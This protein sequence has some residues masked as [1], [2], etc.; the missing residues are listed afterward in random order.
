GSSA[1][2]GGAGGRYQGVGGQAGFGGGAGGGSN[3]DGQAGGGP[4]F[5]GGGGGQVGSSPATTYGGAAGANG[6]AGGGGAAL[7]GAIFVREGGNLVIEGT[8]TTGSSI[9]AGAGGTGSGFAP[10]GSAGQATGTDIFLMTGTG[11]TVQGTTNTSFT[12]SI[13]SQAGDTGISKSGS[14]ILTLSNDNNSYTGGTSVTGGTM[15]ITNQKNIGTGNLSVSNGGAV[16]ASASMDVKMAVTV[17]GAGSRFTSGVGPAALSIGSTGSG[18]LTVTNGGNATSLGSIVFGDFNGVTG[19]GSVNGTGSSLTATTSVVLGS[20]GTG[21]LSVGSGGTVTTG[22]LVFS[23]NGGPG[24]L[25]LNSGGTLQVGGTNGI[26][27]SGTG[28]FNLAGGI[29]KVTN[30]S[31]TSSMNMI[32]SNS[33]LID[34]SGVEGVLSGVLSGSG[35]LSKTGAGT[36][37]LTGDNTYSGT[38]TLY[39]G[40]LIID[41][42]QSGIGQVS[43]LTGSTLGGDGTLG[44]SLHLEADANLSFDPLETLTIN[45]AAVTFDGFGIR[46]VIGLNAS[47]DIGT[48]TLLNG[49]AAFDFSNVSNFGVNNAYALGGGKFAY[50]QEG[51]FEVVVVPEPS[52]M[53][54]LVL[55]ASLVFYRQKRRSA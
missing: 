30:S 11:L 16:V 15:A 12:G 5:G 44:G 48:Y 23:S 21:T 49:S 7:G 17:D 1:D 43:I 2:F 39:A 28:T 4:G 54:L 45:G 6:G 9:T 26:R 46:N 47:T 25:N 18:S 38:T 27:N 31:L 3:S 13:A 40:V 33:S 55:A 52:T 20:T 35:A 37:H 24:T 19:T 29:L 50:F 22:E 32:L 14:G 41:G 53:T 8:S 36:L 34:T 10:G 51:S 42:N